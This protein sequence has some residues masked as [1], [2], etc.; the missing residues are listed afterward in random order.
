MEG[1]VRAGWTKAL[2]AGT[3]GLPA[4]VRRSVDAE[5]G[6]EQRALIQDS[7]NLRW[8]PLAAHLALLRGLRREAT[9]ETVVGLFVEA[10]R[11]NVGPGGIFGKAASAALRWLTDDPF[12]VLR[13]VPTS[14]GYV[15]RGI[16]GV[17][18]EEATPDVRLLVH[19]DWPAELGEGDGFW[20]GWI[21]SLQAALEAGVG[22]RPL[23]P[24]VTLDALDV[25]AARAVFRCEVEVMP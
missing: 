17:H 5:L 2:L 14:T 7:I 4:A 20:L 13:Y 8:I 21:G 3:A 9:E 22:D 18:V 19:R 6:P 11:L 16:G 10:T 24:K 25:R 23:R 12:A 15:F 1:E